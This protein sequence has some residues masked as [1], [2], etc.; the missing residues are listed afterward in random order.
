MA[1]LTNQQKEHN[2]YVPGYKAEHIKNHTWRTAENSAAYMLPK[3]QE[4]VKEKPNLKLLDCGAGPGTITA[5]LAKYMP[6]G[7]PLGATRMCRQLY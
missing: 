7:E 1:D 6:Q 3:L 5:S 4:M 2:A